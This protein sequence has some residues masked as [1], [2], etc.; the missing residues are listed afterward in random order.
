MKINEI[1]EK[2]GYTKTLNKCE[3]CRDAKV[4]YTISIFNGQEYNKSIFC[5]QNEKD[6]RTIY[7]AVCNNHMYGEPNREEIT[8]K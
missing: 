1:K 6:F 4:L 7:N 2:I 8:N 5:T 3:N